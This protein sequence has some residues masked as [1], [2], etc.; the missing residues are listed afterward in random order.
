MVFHHMDGPVQKCYSMSA[1]LRYSKKT[2]V[3]VVR[4]LNAIVNTPLQSGNNVAEAAIA[5][6]IQYF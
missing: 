1:S 4:D 5:T 2:A 3:T 6:G